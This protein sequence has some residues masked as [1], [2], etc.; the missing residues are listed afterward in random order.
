[1]ARVV[2]LRKTLE[3][4]AGAR[5]G[6]GSEAEGWRRGERWKR[7]NCVSLTW[8]SPCWKKRLEIKAQTPAFFLLE[9]ART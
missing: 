6:G 2:H 4:D 3:R 5:Q 8:E 1:M 9:Q 7:S